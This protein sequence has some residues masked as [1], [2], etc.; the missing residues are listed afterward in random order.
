MSKSSFFIRV[1]ILA[2]RFASM[3][4]IVAA[5]IKNFEDNNWNTDV[6]ARAGVEFENL[7]VLSRK[8]LI[9]AEYYKMAFLLVGIL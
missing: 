4:P 1:H 6:S 7:Q 3:W 5:D 8:L 2:H 9:F